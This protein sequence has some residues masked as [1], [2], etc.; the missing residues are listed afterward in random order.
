MPSEP[1]RH[2]LGCLADSPEFPLSSV[3]CLSWTMIDIRRGLLDSEHILGQLCSPSPYCIVHPLCR[4]RADHSGNARPD[5]V[6]P[7]VDSGATT[8][9]KHPLWRYRPAA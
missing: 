3:R 2:I 7:A 5:A 1:S 8:N 9:Q 6:A 4:P